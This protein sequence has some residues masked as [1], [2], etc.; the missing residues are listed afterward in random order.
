MPH[1]AGTPDIL[2]AILTN[3]PTV[4]MKL[5]EVNAKD[6]SKTRSKKVATSKLNPVIKWT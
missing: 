2:Q 1:P 6:K 3:I 5:N 4:I